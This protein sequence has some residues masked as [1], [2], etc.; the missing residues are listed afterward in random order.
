MQPL[1]MT[2]LASDQIRVKRSFNAPVSLV[3]RA[4]TEPE[5]VKRWLTGPPGHTMP[6]CE[7]DL[8]EGGAWRY[9]WQMPE[10]QMVAYGIYQAIEPC[11]QIIHT[12]IFEQWPDHPSLITTTF[13]ELYGQ[14]YGQTLV[15]TVIHYDSEATR[16]AV[17]KTGMASGM[18]MSYAKL[19]SLLP[20]LGSSGLYHQQNSSASEPTE[21]L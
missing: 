1:T 11:Q 5:L 20:T 18:E 2:Q 9:V 13:S 7:I 17:L 16:D 14:T 21:R 10:G 8:R 15:T 19:D 12:E 4:Y 6:I 3:W